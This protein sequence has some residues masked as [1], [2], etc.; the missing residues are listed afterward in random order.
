METRT[1]SAPAGKV[2][3]LDPIWSE[4]RKEAQTAMTAEPALGSFIFAT[5]LS[6]DR[7]EDAICHRLAQRIQHADVD[8]VLLNQTFQGVLSG[9][10]HLGEVF[11]ADLAAVFDRDPAC[12]RYLE[13]L[14]Y[15]KGFHA[16]VTYRFAHE[17]W[18][19]GRHDFAL[20][21]QSQSA[22][23]F[24]T[25]IHPAA[26]FGVCRLA[27]SSSSGIGSAD[28]GGQIPRLGARTASAA[29]SLCLSV[30]T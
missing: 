13:P 14:L 26:K 6:H 21:L 12:N 19:D 1:R 3:A 8:A 10:Q 7:L 4:T 27:T 18:N 15:Y 16:L 30:Q 5:V 9:H 17:L 22:H 23:M 24:S 29:M 11:R 25:D 20:Y 28:F 2:K